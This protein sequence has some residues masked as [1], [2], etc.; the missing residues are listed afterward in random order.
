MTTKKER[1]AEIKNMLV[2]TKY[3]KD[4]L[5]S[6][7]EKAWDALEFYA[8]GDYYHQDEFGEVQVTEGGNIARKALEE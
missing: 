5:I 2:D 8:S 6:E 3:G 4:W 7:L 1:L